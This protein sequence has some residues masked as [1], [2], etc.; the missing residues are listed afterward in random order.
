[1]ASRDHA[2]ADCIALETR[3]SERKAPLWV[4][5]IGGRYYDGGS[6][7]TWWG[8]FSP[9]R[10]PVGLS[11]GAHET[12]HLNI[13]VGIGQVFIRLPFLDR[14]ADRG[15]NDNW[16]F[17]FSFF[18]S[19]DGMQSVHLNWGTATKIINYPW[20]RRFLFRE[21]L[22]ESGEWLPH[23]RR[24][25]SWAPGEGVKP[26]TVEEPYH[27]LLDSGSVQS[28]TASVVRE[29]SWTVWVWF[30]EGKKAR[31]SNALRELQRR[32]STPN[33]GLDI[34]F[35]AEVGGRAGSWKG[36]CVG[37]GWNMNPGETVKSALLRMQRERRFR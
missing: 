34:E 35:S 14:W 23:D 25:R 1:M 2:L 32:L 37:C 26:L 24:E 18:G 7:R 28:V 21:F 19:T 5:L 29:R 33:D 11:V 20:Q 3:A 9:A 31:L 36:G 27:Y 30:G 8:E 10:S 13:A 4:R 12:A 16:R 17:G 15:I 6:V 22:T